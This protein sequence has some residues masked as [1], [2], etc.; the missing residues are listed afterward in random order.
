MIVKCLNQFCRLYGQR[1][2][3][4]CE[5]FIE[6]DEVRDCPARLKYENFKMNVRSYFNETME[7]LGE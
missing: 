7:E 1:I 5:E 2:T 6:D 3:N 4:G